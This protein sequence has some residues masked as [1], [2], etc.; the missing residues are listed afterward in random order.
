MYL[1]HFAVADEHHADFILH[2]FDKLIFFCG[3]NNAHIQLF[4]KRVMI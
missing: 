2:H 4:S 3:Y 1:N